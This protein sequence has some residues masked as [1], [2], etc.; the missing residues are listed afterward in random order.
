MRNIGISAH[1]DSGKTTLTE[2]ILYYTGR[3]AKIHEVKGKDNV[4]AKMDS[5]ELERQKGITIK[6]A[7]TYCRWGEHHFNIIDTPGHVDFTIEVERSL[8][9]LDGAILVVCG[10]SGV[11]SQTL[12]VD[13][14]MR[15]YD[16][17]RITFINKLDRM[18]A[19]PWKALSELRA[20]LPYKVAAIQV[21]IGL[22]GQFSGIIDIIENKAYSYEG[23]SGE[24]IQE[25]PVPEGYLDEV[26]QKR[27]ELLEVLYEL[28][29]GLAEIFIGEGREPT[30]AEIKQ[31]IRRATISLKFSPVLMGSAYKN[32][33]VQNLLNGVVDYLPNPTEVNNYA[34]DLEKNEERIKLEPDHSKPFVGL[35]FKLEESPFGQLTYMRLYQG[36]L[37]R[38]DS[39]LNV[40]SGKKVR[41]P[42]LIRMHSD[43]MEDIQEVGAGEICALFGVECSSGTTFTDGTVKYSM[44]SMFIPEPVISLAIWAKNKGA[45]KQLSK[46]LA[47][48]QREDPTFRVHTDPE[49]QQIIISGM[50]ELHLEIYME[51][52]RREYAVDVECSPP[53]VAYRETLTQRAEFDFTHKKQ[54]GGAGQYARVA[55]YVEPLDEDDLD[56]KDRAAGKKVLFVNQTVGGSI[57]PNF[58]PACE[59]GVM[60]AVAEGPTIGH[61][62]ENVRVVIND[63][64]WHS[65][66]SSELA[67][68]I[69]TINAFRQGVLKANPIVLEPVMKVEVQV[70]REFQSA[71][72]S[73]IGRRKGIIL[74]SEAKA[75]EDFITIDAEVPLSNMVG[76]ST[77][78]RSLTQGKGEF[79]MEFT[80]YAPVSRD[81]QEKLMAKY[82]EE[83]AKKAK[84]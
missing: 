21:P 7:A 8:R 54:S 57:P 74:N 65:V 10:V 56:E 41:V 16:V 9:V 36:M 26:A 1:I 58:I 62:I 81:A 32:K 55:G 28:D 72:T 60:E 2:R 51:R 18:G 29:D 77:D 15:R 71:V 79:S 67:F 31:G 48:F 53:R 39:L 78:L 84:E 70:P 66:D 5:M 59:K 35:A 40:V 22:E 17:P 30:P 6:S 25:K 13:R 3:I 50:G 49:S 69:A 73:S 11:Q 83:R 34:L 37:K 12:T 23:N 42:R 4:G 63:G 45:D 64:S 24:I 44:T 43:E 27:K 47:R 68:R 19:N 14:Q 82:K 38:S 61:P 46:A 52:M 76:Y 75:G 20:K 33:G 80:K